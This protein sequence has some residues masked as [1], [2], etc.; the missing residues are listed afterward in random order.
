[1]AAT[2]R[3]TGS[4]DAGGLRT[5]AEL[6]LPLAAGGEFA[7]AVVE[8]CNETPGGSV[9]EDDLF[10]EDGE[11]HTNFLYEQAMDEAAI[12]FVG[13]GAT[14]SLKKG[15]MTGPHGGTQNYEI[16]DMSREPG[17][18]AIR[19]SISVRKLHTVT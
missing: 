11:F 12:V 15:S 2:Q 3:G 14:T 13:D 6:Y 8:S 5:R 19:F 7:D 9:Q 4:L 17:K 1:M 16:T 10:D 18:G